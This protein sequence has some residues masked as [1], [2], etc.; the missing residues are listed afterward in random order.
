M[1]NLNVTNIQHES[2]A[3]D[4]LILAAD[5]TTTIPGGT[6]RPKIAGYQQGTWD[7]DLIGATNTYPPGTTPPT[8]TRVGQLVFLCGRFSFADT[9]NTSPIIIEGVPYPVQQINGSANG[10]FTGSVMAMNGDNATAGMTAF[11]ESTNG[12][13]N[14]S[15]RFYR[16]KSSTSFL[17]YA[18]SDFKTSQVIFSISYLTDDTTWQP[19][20]GATVAP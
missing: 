11:M 6:N 9:T 14:T 16:N 4:N 5:G 1:S 12:G 17:Q 3:G 13:V 2:G 20:N 18:Y 7:L 15:V 19:D 8:W 10:L